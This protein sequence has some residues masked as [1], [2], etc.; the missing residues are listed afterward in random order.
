MSHLT[1]ARERLKFTR[2]RIKAAPDPSAPYVPTEQD[3][4]LLADFTTEARKRQ[5]S[6][7]E[8]F[9]KSVL[10]LSTG[11]LAFSL[12]FLKD[13]LPINAAI[14]PGTLYWSWWLLT[15]AIISTM[16]S[17]LA[18]MQAQE[19]K[20]GVAEDYYLRGINRLEETSWWDTAVTRLNHISGGCFV[21]GVTLTT[22][23]V[24]LNLS[25][26]QE[27]KNSRPPI[28]HD[29]L[30]SPT[31]QQIANVVDQ[32]RGINSPG[33]VPSAPRPSPP[34]PPPPPPPPTQRKAVA[35]RPLAQC[36]CMASAPAP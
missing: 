19:F 7:S 36:Q 24:A 10:T 35:E 6:G 30:P 1:A 28:T 12:G 34:P 26:A 3:T 9:D 27:M 8:N 16:L 21:V 22:L 5:V 17:F 23:F 25:K 18:S 11:S 14:L 13:F 29:G 33:I 2:R 20:Q 15:A 4:K 32:R 31:I